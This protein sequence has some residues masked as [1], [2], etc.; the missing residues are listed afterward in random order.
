MNLFNK[1]NSI[2]LKPKTTWFFPIPVPSKAVSSQKLVDFQEDPPV[3]PGPLNPTEHSIFHHNYLP[4]GFH[5]VIK[6]PILWNNQLPSLQMEAVPNVGESSIGKPA[7]GGFLF[8]GSSGVAGRGQSN[9]SREG[10]SFPFLINFLFW[11][12]IG[13]TEKFYFLCISFFL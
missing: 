7:V 5:V 13:Y 11:N 2:I 1:L 12:N 10:K 3:F 6:C 8:V 9:D 4:G